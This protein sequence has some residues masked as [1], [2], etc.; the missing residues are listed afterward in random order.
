M[1][2]DRNYPGIRKRY[3]KDE[4]ADDWRNP[5]G[6]VLQKPLPT[7]FR[8]NV[9]PDVGCC[10]VRADRSRGIACSY[11]HGK[12]AYGE[13][14]HKRPPALDP[15][16]IRVCRMQHSLSSTGTFKHIRGNVCGQACR[17]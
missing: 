8:S 3:L 14:N 12:R 16:P 7:G 13:Q 4:G 6:G 15:R 2:S 1:R 9:V 5:G 10:A 17:P 11:T